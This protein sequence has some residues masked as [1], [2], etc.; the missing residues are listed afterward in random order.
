MGITKARK[1]IEDLIAEEMQR[2][3]TVQDWRKAARSAVSGPSPASYA[4]RIKQLGET[5]AWLH[6]AQEAL[7]RAEA[8]ENQEAATND[9]GKGED[10]QTSDADVCA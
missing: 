2:Y 9:D 5:I 3:R 6:Q 1:N 4:P 8:V 10:L 7:V